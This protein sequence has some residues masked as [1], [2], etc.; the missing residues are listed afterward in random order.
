MTR[1]LGLSVTILV[2]MLSDIGE[3]FITVLEAISC[4]NLIFFHIASIVSN[5]SY[6]TQQVFE[7]IQTQ[8]KLHC[9]KTNLAFL[10]LCNVLRTNLNIFNYIN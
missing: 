1:V 6:L 9:N 5:V 3:I 8:L 2:K 7:I 10:K 4:Y